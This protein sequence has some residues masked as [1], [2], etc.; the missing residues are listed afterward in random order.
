MRP[1]AP[2]T[3][4]IIYGR[5]KLGKS[6]LLSEPQSLHLFF[7]FS[8]LELDKLGM[9]QEEIGQPVLAHWRVNGQFTCKLSLQTRT[10]SYDGTHHICT[11]QYS[12]QQPPV[13]NEYVKCGWYVQETKLLFNFNEFKLK[14]PH[15]ASG[16]HIGQ[17]SLDRKLHEASHQICLF[18]PISLTPSGGTQLRS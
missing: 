2:R 10:F 16:H 6:H 4:F 5:C 7:L 15:V 1:G 17:H 18:I 13:A 14:Q 3:D 9:Q 8:S 11:I 12:N